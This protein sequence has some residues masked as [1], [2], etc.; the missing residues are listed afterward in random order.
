MQHSQQPFVEAWRSELQ[1][2]LQYLRAGEFDNA[3]ACFERAY[4]LEP[5]RAEV[6]YAL[7]KER[8]RRD[9]IE[10]AEALLR[11]AWDQDSSLISAAGTLA[12]CLGLHAR[13]FD[14]AH[15][16]LDQAQARHGAMGLLHVVR[17]E[18]LLGQ[19][20]LDEA[21]AQAEAALAGPD[22]ESVR[23]AAHAALARVYNREGIALA[24]R[25][26]YES[27]LFSF[28]RA[29]GLDPDWSNPHTNM[30]AAF[31]YLGKPE[32]AL[33]AYEHA[34]ALEPD[35]AIAHYNLGVLL[36]D[37]GDLDSARE[38]LERAREQPSMFIEATFALA[39]TWLDRDPEAAVDLLV[40]VL[41]RY[42][43][44]PDLWARLGDVFLSVGERDHA[45]GCWRRALDLDPAHAAACY[46]LADQLARESRFAEAALLA[47][48]A[49]QRKDSAPS[50]GFAP[51]KP[52]RQQ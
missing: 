21:R 45:E 22:R 13:R 34:L 10:A 33:R 35:S 28:K 37:A 48:R 30:G 46:A 23:E 41:E 4:R 2:G 47:Q 18:L 51:A 24:E 32:L 3:L 20:R 39:E 5:D 40:Q 43:D 15:A 12:R 31:V 1:R 42:P 19:D 38:A 9:D 26:A 52:D 50:H 44:E 17:S 8:M 14:E 11:T 29:A 27:A 49:Q 16:V 7:G 6:C 36:R 25:G